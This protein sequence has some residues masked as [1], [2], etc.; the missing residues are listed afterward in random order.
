[1]AK[2]K[3]TR[4]QKAAAIERCRDDQGRLTP[5]FVW[6]A[7]KEKDSDLHDEFDW[8]VQRAAEQTWE[9][10]AAELIREVKFTVVYETRKIA[11]PYYVSDPRDDQSSYVPVADVSKKPAWAEGVMR[12]ELDR[13]RASV[14][15]A[16]ALAVA[17][18]LVDMFEHVLE[19]VTEIER[20][21][22][23]GES[24]AGPDAAHA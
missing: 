1:M 14:H 16:K 20:V 12:D 9:R 4:E 6:M 24:G 5:T 21:L 11:V 17:F 22:G 13:I 8:N 19:Q 18:D 7:A 3:L 2:K 23:G 10:R 15:R